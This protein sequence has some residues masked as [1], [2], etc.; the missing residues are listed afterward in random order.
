M[1]HSLSIIDAWRELLDAA[2]FLLDPLLAGLLIGSLAPLIGGYFL[3]RRILFLGVTI[4]QVSSAG[5][6]F[7]L[8]AQGLG[9]FGMAADPHGGNAI[10]LIGSLLF[11][12]IAVIALGTIAHRK[13][14]FSDVAI[15]FTFAVASALSFLLLSQNPIAEAGMLNLLKG[16]II[17][18]GR[19]DLAG[20]AIAWTI[21]IATLLFL[22]KEFLLV[23]YDREFA[24]AL[25][26][27]VAAYDLI[28]HIVAALAISLCVLTVGPVTTFGYL[29]LPPMIALL[30]PLGMSRFFLLSSLIGMI[31]SVV[32]LA[33]AFL[34]DLPV[35]PTTVAALALAWLLGW[36]ARR[37][38]QFPSRS[39]GRS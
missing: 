11:T 35:G 30:F 10:P 2:P 19:R 8:L 1:P 4:P 24:V 23:S 5:I 22:H 33:A 31:A 39:R 25:R 21:S 17:A 15:G 6:A 12:T 20:T 9:W 29:I 14:G 26:K 18:I 36:I 34:L 38:A 3:L 13:P 27:P 16:E 28:F 37:I 32:S 7:A